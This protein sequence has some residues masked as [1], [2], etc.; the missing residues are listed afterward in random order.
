MLLT[1]GPSKSLLRTAYKETLDNT[2]L[3]PTLAKSALQRGVGAVM[4]AL[5]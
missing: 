1:S 3:R 2:S 5:V 4:R